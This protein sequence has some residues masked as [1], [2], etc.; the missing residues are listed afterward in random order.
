MRA[1]G[2]RSCCCPTA[3]STC[4]AG[5]PAR[6]CAWT[7]RPRRSNRQPLCFAQL[8]H[9]RADL[10]ER[11]V[12]GHAL[13]LAVDELHRVL[14]AVLAVPV[15]AQRAAP[16]GAVRA[17]VE[18][19][20]EYRFPAAPTRRFSTTASTRAADRAVAAHGALDLDLAFAGR[21]RFLP[22]RRASAFFTSV[23]FAGNQPG[24]DAEGRSGAGRRGGPSSESLGR[25]RARGW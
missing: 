3:T 17:E 21:R 19:R 23:S 20:I 25:R 1:L 10:F 16:F 5:K 24:A 6:C 2:G 4:A 8:E 7:S 11:L 12:P 15:L 13:V 14:E 18:R 9:L 22:D